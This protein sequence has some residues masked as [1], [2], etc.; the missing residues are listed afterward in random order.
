MGAMRTSAQIAEESLRRSLGLSFFGQRFANPAIE[1]D[2][3]VWRLRSVIPTMRMGLLFSIGSA[4]SAIPFA[5]LA[6]PA[7]YFSIVALIAFAIV[8][9]LFLSMS[10]TYVDRLRG[11]VKF[12]TPLANTAAGLASVWMVHELL[13]SVAITTAVTIMAIF[14]A[15]TIFRTPPE[16][17]TFAVVPY[18]MFDLAL[19]QHDFRAGRLT[20]TEYW[21]NVFL[22]LITLV[23]AL[24]IS[25][26]FENYTR[27]LYRSRRV[28]REQNQ[29]LL[30]ERA[31]LSR[32]M[33]PEIAD[34]VREQGIPAT[35][36][37][38]TLDITAVCCDLRGFTVYTQRHGVLQ[39]GAVLR[40][41]YEL[42]IRV[43]A[44]YGGTIKD[45]AGDGGLIL[46]GAPVARE[47][48]ADAG[49]RLARELAAA[50]REMTGGLTRPE[51]PLGFSIAVA[52]GPCAVGAIGSQTRLEYTAVGPAVNLAARLCTH[53][54]DGEIYLC[55][56]AAQQVREPGAWARK[57]I[58]L[59][60]FAEPVEV[61][62]ESVH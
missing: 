23:S 5:W 14:F 55:S 49:M 24:M 62:V 29:A 57:A 61:V 60:G 36:H 54:G 3:Q 46:L 12:L 15:C 33:A 56:R 50:L 41:Y 4:V 32:F 34:L 47:D 59:K 19:L 11:L 48:H 10:L 16:I 52:T 40:E 38:K 28:I 45:F 2:Y 26:V 7:R 22:P 13:S 1:K 39:M 8:P 17:A 9:L 42:I 18:L 35:L 44:R 37:L 58:G 27:V 53:A 25:G 43:S 6:S 21:A 30:E 51:S 31:Q 20:Q